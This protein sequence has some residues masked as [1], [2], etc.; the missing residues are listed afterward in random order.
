MFQT[1]PHM[2]FQS[3]LWFLEKPVWTSTH[4]ERVKHLFRLRCPTLAY[5][6]QVERDWSHTGSAPR[7]PAVRG[8]EGTGKRG[9]SRWWHPHCVRY[10]RLTLGC[11]QV[12]KLRVPN[13]PAEAWDGH[14]WWGRWS[15]RRALSNKLPKML[16]GGG[17][18]LQFPLFSHYLRVIVEKFR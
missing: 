4:T 5:T 16:R 8:A 10:E 6:W 11:C 9:Q 13:G 3:Y 1:S 2:V 14:R 7:A 17:S 12:S 15:Q 18:K